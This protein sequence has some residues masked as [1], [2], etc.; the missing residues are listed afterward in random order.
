M[1]S[2]TLKQ[3]RYFAAL[4]REK[5]FGRAAET[6]SITQPALSMQIQELEALLGVTL[7]ERTRGG[8]RLTQTGATIADRANRIL[9]DTRD[10]VELAQHGDQLM[11]GTLRLGVIPSVAPYLLPP[12]LPILQDT[13]PDLEL[14]VRETQTAPLTG[15]L[16][17]GQLDVMLLAL[18]VEHPDVETLRLFDDNFLLAL[19]KRRK[20]GA[21]VRATPDLI[22]NE[23]LLLLEEGHCLREQALQYCSLQQVNAVDAFGASSLGTIVEMV[24]AGLGITLLPEICRRAESRSRNITLMRFSAPEPY[25]T[26]GLAWRKTSPRR[27]DFLELG[28]LLLQAR[29]NLA[30]RFE[31][32]L[33]DPNVALGRVKVKAKKKKVKR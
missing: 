32:I 21:R 14:H 23:R 19:P 25:R 1:I 16:V 17:D 6:C 26:L 4:A 20:V 11:S 31:E 10:L 30:T 24:S 29:E 12:L 2:I 5:H 28:R 33:D 18:P 7:V 8:V 15:E 9:S 13:Y 22:R 3:L 27:R